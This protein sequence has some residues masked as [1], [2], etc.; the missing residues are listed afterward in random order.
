MEDTFD[1]IVIG[2][3]IVGASTAY[4][5]ASTG[6][7]TVLIDR[8][9][10]GRATSAGAGIL[11]PA[12]SSRTADDDWFAFATD[13]VAYYPTLQERL[14][15]DGASETSYRRQGAIAVAIDD[16]E[17]EPY[18]DARARIRD[19][20]LDYI[21]EID[22]ADAV[23]RFPALEEPRRAFYNPTAGRVD[24]RA[25]AESLLEA[26]RTHGLTTIDGEVENLQMSSD[27]VS[28]VETAGGTHIDAGNIVIAG[29]A[30]SPAF[31]AQLDVEIPV[32]PQRGQVAHLTLP[33]TDTSAWPIVGGF[34]HHY[35]VPWPDG[36]IVLGATRESEVGFDPTLTAQGV[37]EVL[38]E[39]LRV[40]PGLTDATLEELRVGLR[41]VSADGLPILGA[42]PNVDGAY[43]ATGHGATGLMLGPYSG[44]IISDAITG[45]SAAIPPSLS[46]TRLE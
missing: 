13:A 29:G 21:E 16:D 35:I 10:D 32:E 46:V 30:W 17:L 1:T 7:D 42:V 4:H 18:A 22:P 2:G 5:L 26:G 20:D 27:G 36:R 41:P 19:R 33:E 38:T 31:G 9:D 24:G 39:G 23:N 15:R 40:A 45:T 34:R 8:N 28:G 44:K 11:S 12:T 3:G 37:N 6:V 43:V 25:F 14:E